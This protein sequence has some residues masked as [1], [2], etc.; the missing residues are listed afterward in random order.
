M[1]ISGFDEAMRLESSRL[2]ARGE[3]LP[4]QG[5]PAYQSLKS[6]VVDELVQQA[7][8]TLEAVKLGVTVSSADVRDRIDAIEKDDYHGSRARLHA[9]LVEQGLTIA[10]LQAQVAQELLENALFDAVTK[11]TLVSVAQVRAYYAA[12]LDRYRQPASRRVREVLVG[13]NG[14]LAHRIYTELRAGASFTALVRRY[15]RDITSNTDG[16]SLLAVQGT[17]PLAFDRAVFAASA[18]TD[19]VL[20]PVD[21]EAYGWFVVEPVSPIE[22]GKAIPEATV[23]VAIANQLEQERKTRAMA[24]WVDSVAKSFCADTQIDYRPGY[25][26]VPNPCRR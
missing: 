12:H 3:R 17:E 6:R 1:T 5:T 21:T 11:D 23:S 15:S 2:K 25:A 4:K 16:G 7:E 22:P 26:P 10:D 20:P 8:F 9:A 24:D 14:A 13:R 19:T 18:E